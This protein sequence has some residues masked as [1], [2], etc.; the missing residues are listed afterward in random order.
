MGKW[1]VI[2][3]RQVIDNTPALSEDAIGGSLALVPQPTRQW[4]CLF[5]TFKKTAPFEFIRGVPAESR[6]RDSAMFFAVYG[7]L[8]LRNGFVGIFDLTRIKDA[9]VYSDLYRD[10][11]LAAV[12]DGFRR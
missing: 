6:H 4:V 11:F 3:N 7:R 10:P 9:A 12:H 8:R 1:S 5:R 2:N